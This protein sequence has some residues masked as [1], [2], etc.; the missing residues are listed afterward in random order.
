MLGWL[1][2]RRQTVGPAGV[3][4]YHRVS[5]LV[6]ELTPLGIAGD[7][8]MRE[9]LSLMRSGCVIAEHMSVDQVDHGDLVKIGPAGTTHMELVENVDY[10]AACA[11]DAWVR[12]PEL[13]R[14]VADR[15][16]DRTRHYQFGTTLRNAADFAAYLEKEYLDLI[17]LHDVYLRHIGLGELVAVSQAKRVVKKRWDAHAKKSPYF[18]VERRFPVGSEVVGKVKNLVSFGFFVTVPDGPDA[19]VHAVRLKR[20]GLARWRPSVGEQFRGRVVVA[21]E[22][23][24]KFELAPV[25]ADL[26]S[27]DALPSVGDV[28]TGAIL[29][30]KAFGFFV[31]TGAMRD[32]LLSRVRMEREGWSGRWPRVGD[33]VRCEVVAVSEKGVEGRLLAMVDSDSGA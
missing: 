5:D 16:G 15:V 31:E 10:L 24:G 11:E 13:A 30:E 21:D 27:G 8:V 1:E 14:A 2:S 17:G 29:S 19:L 20:M 9:V 23:D 18:D 22:I 3:K 33:V 4:G 32:V 26:A 7:A 6:G 28:V 25:D 12:N